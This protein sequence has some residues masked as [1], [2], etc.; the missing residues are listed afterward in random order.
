M[1]PTEIFLMGPWIHKS[2]LIYRLQDKKKNPILWN[3]PRVLLTGITPYSI[4]ITGD[5]VYLSNTSNQ[6]VSQIRNMEKCIVK[7]AIRRKCLDEKK[8][9]L[10]SCIREWE[11]TPYIR[12]SICRDNTTGKTQC[13]S[14]ENKEAVP[15]E[16]E[17]ISKS[18]L[19]QLRIWIRDFTVY[20]DHCELH[21]V[22]QQILLKDPLTTKKCLIDEESTTQSHCR[23]TINPIYSEK[24]N[25]TPQNE[26]KYQKMLRMGIPPHVVELKRKNDETLG[27][28]SK[29][30]P[31]ANILG[32]IL[33]GKSH[34]KKT[35]I[36]KKKHFTKPN[37]PGCV[38][39]LDEILHQR[40]NLQKVS[41]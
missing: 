32:G 22:A 4:F 35:V 24:K 15:V 2:N 41:I 6:L 23:E 12:I 8:H 19:V 21:L 38:P 20:E 37:I 25:G 16:L 28:M 13:F 26:D 33:Q 14:Q 29:P 40:R 9:P 34:L 17:E 31:I 1:I 36:T 5:S 7:E 30:N 27:D 18:S 11:G 39:S 3:T 10:M